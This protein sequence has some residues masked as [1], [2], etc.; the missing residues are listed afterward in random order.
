MKAM[1]L[2]EKQMMDF[3]L[4][5]SSENVHYETD[6]TIYF[7]L[8]GG[9]SVGC[10]NSVLSLAEKDFLIVNPYQLHSVELEEHCLAMRFLVNLGKIS[11]FYDI[12]ELDFV[13]NSVEEESGQ[14]MALRGLLEKCVAF[15]YGK[16]S[17]NGR[18]LLKLNSLYYNI[19]ELLISSFSVVKNRN[20]DADDR[21]FDESLIQEMTRYVHM[22]Y[23]SPVKLEDLAEHFFLSTAYISRFFKKKLGINFTKYLTDIRLDEAVKRLETTDKTLT[24]IAMDCGFPNLVSFNAAFKNRYQM[25]PK[26]YRASLPRIRPG[27]TEENMDSN[28]AEFHLLEYFEE[29]KNLIEDDY[30]EME[31]IEADTG[32]YTI[33][34][35]NWNKMI[36]IGGVSLLLQKEMQDHTVFLCKTLGCEYVRIWDLYEKRMH[37]NAGNKSGKYNFNRLDACLDFLTE[38]NIMPYMELGFK[39]FILLKNFEEYTFAEEREIPF[40]GPEEYGGFVRS[41]LM[42]LVNR[43]SLRQ[44][45]AW[46]FEVWCDPRWFPEGDASEYIAYFEQ[47][48][49]AVKEVS[50]HSRVG[51]AYDRSYGIIS[52]ESFIQQWSSRN[53]QPDFLSV[54][55][56]ESLIRDVTP[57]DGGRWIHDAEEKKN[58]RIEA[59]LRSRKQILMNYGMTMPVYS[60]EWNF[61]VINANVMND[62]RFKGAYMMKKIM[63]LYQD[64]D[65]LGYW[66][67]TDFFVDEDEAPMLLN[68]RCGLITHQGICKPAYWAV[69][70]MNRLE[71]YLLKKTDNAMVTMDDFDS[72]VIA[73]HNFKELDIQYY[74]QEER[75]VT[76]ES[77]PHLYDNNKSLIMKITITGVK[78]GIYHIK[79]RVVNSQYGCVQDE[80]IRMGNIAFLTAAD[81]E[82]I[83]HMSRPHITISEQA[84]T[85]HTLRFTTKLEPQEIQSIH[86]FRYMEETL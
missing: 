31:Q 18:I 13:G 17:N 63:N 9:L 33:L 29:S 51:G 68:G 53:I 8:N 57:E 39:P 11:E 28:Q 35:K 3:D 72:Y 48:Y 34:T 86:A 46:I 70:M 10:S 66:F 52:F 21:E 84:V 7:V 26:E 77:I 65:L 40:R 36:N 50:P 42:H 79:T 59:Y 30:E 80:W 61:T 25:S 54:Y 27:E 44:V 82:Y 45:S 69:R 4:L 16:R 22:N 32:H 56:Y 15:Y 73:C 5:V 38:H 41:L 47:A 58:F 67:G 14:H 55:C 60:S 81:V 12:S 62:S 23:Q 85:D 83:D 74:V 75:D 49:Q 6:L 20:V 64:L 78:N 37:I 2:D 76:I 1:T 71:D 43:Y 24:W 19:A